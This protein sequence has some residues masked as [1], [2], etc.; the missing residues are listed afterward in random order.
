MVIKHLVHYKIGGIDPEQDME[1]KTGKHQLEAPPEE[2]V[3]LAAGKD[4]A[5]EAPIGQIGR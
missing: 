4:F 3:F 2:P 5:L 1:K